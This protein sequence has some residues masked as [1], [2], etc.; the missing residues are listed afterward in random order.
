VQ[1]QQHTSILQSQYTDTNKTQNTKNV[2]NNSQQTKH[3]SVANQFMF[4]II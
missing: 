3:K 4:K 1:V 2:H